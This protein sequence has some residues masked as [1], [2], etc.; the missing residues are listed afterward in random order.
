MAFTVKHLSPFYKT[1]HY[2]KFLTPTSVQED[3]VKFTHILVL[4]TVILD[5]LGQTIQAYKH[6]LP[7]STLFS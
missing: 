4:M 1:A 3:P 2:D 5:N 6:S 7:T